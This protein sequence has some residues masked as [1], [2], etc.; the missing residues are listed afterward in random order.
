MKSSEITCPVCGFGHIHLFV[1]IPQVPVHC[2]L[3]WTDR[4]EALKAPK[5]DVQLGFCQVCGHIFNVA[6]DPKVMEYTQAY[7]NSLH[8]SPRF[9]SYAASLARRLIERYG[10]YGKDVVEI[11]S[12]Q[13]DFMRLLCDLGGNRGFGF[14]PSYAPE[15]SPATA[16]EQITFIQDF[17]S[18]RYASYQADLICCRHVLEHIKNP[19]DFVTTVRKAI[20]CRTDTAV[21]FE[22]P[23]MLFT[24]R[25][26]AIW[27][28]IYE[29]CSYFG[30]HSLGYLFRRCGFDVV[31]ITEAFAGQFLSIEALPG[32]QPED[33]EAVQNEPLGDMHENVRAFAA[34]YRQRVEGWQR[35]LAEITNAG[36]RAV[37]W[38]AGSKGVTFLNTLEL[39]SQ[40][41]Y[42]VDINP[43]KQG[44]YIAGTGQQV[45]PPECLRDYQPNLLIVMNSVYESEIQRLVGDLG[46]TAELVCA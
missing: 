2:N 16:S 23:N 27:D 30:D 3:L 41:E 17:Y 13:G 7:E 6:F 8:F 39:Q 12:G 38:G 5:G 34:R 18:E 19:T 32:Q 35:N 36:Q 37:V 4:E 28:I 44:M 46:L 15:S 21:Y 14:D 42:V 43:R 11:G 22:V 33:W 10:L 20:G 31:G 24:L 9:Q 25:E 29:H 26:L 40:I 1:T 45:V